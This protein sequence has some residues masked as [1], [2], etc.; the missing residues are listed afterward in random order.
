M[1]I[2]KLFAFT[3]RGFRLASS[4]RLNFV[5]TY[6]GG[7]L[8]IV[9]FAVLEKAFGSRPAAVA[10]YGDYFTF[11]LIGGIFARYL[12]FG[13]RHFGRELEQELIA[14]TLEPML[15]TGTQPALILLGPSLWVAIEGLILMALQFAVGA[16]FFAADFSRANWPAAFVI[17]LLSFVALSFW[18]VLAAAF[19]VVFKRADPLSWLIDVT[20]FLLAGV[21]FPVTLLPLWLKIP[22]YL[23]PLSYSLEALRLAVMRGESIRDLAGYAGIL[24]LFNA[25]L[26]P[27]G[28]AG[29]R[30]A[31]THVKRAGTLGHY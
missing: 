9:F 6:L 27:A 26:I 18:G 25:A 8:L 16:R 5:G 13:M 11:L 19:V 2:N 20:I 10:A 30:R 1:L 29:F 7:V 4:Y 21:Y 3:Q 24:L 28:I 22:A 14:G 17:G 12:S 23:M 15:V 31:L